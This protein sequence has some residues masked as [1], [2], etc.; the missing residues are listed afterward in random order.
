MYGGTL[1]TATSLLM[2]SGTVITATSLRQWTLL[3]A[4]S[5]RVNVQWVLLTATSLKYRGTATRGDLIKGSTV[6][7]LSGLAFH[8]LTLCAGMEVAAYLCGKAASIS[9]IDIATVPFERVLGE[10]IGKMLQGVR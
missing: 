7:Q 9:C 8:L 1:L 3:T 6:I 10:R 2:Y 5:L 4:T